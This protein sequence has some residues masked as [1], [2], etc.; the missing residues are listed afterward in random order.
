MANLAAK[1][2]QKSKSDPIGVVGFDV[3]GDE[4]NYPL[5]SP[6]CAMMNGIVR[7]KESGVPITVHAGEWPEKF[8]TINNLKFAVNEIKAHRLGHAITLRSDEKFL[9][10]IGQKLTIEVSTFKYKHVSL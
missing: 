9:Q 6:E 4:G 8:K 7:A 1:Y 5:N 10:S 2:L 3:A